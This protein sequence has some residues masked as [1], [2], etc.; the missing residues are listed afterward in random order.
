MRLAVL[1]AIAAGV[2]VITGSVRFSLPH[3]D[4]RVWLDALFLFSTAVAVICGVGLLASLGGRFL[5]SHMHADSR[6]T[7]DRTDDRPA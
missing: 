2:S 5:R 1:M 6:H 3:P 7:D 4:F